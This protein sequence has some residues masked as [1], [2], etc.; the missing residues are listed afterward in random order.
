MSNNNKKLRQRKESQKQARKQMAKKR[1]D[2]P[3]YK[4]ERQGK[5][6]ISTATLLAV[7]CILI[8]TVRCTISTAPLLAA[9]KDKMVKVKATVSEIHGGSMMNRSK[10]V[11]VFKYKVGDKTYTHEALIAT[12][13]SDVPE[14]KKGD[15]TYVYYQ[16][17]D[18]SEAFSGMEI[19]HKFKSITGYIGIGAI[20]LVVLF[21]TEM[22][23]FS[24]L[25]K[26]L[27]NGSGNAG[28]KKNRK[29]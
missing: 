16:K 28:K 14:M 22:N 9:E 7:L 17:D 4:A 3:G 18:P 12:G 15:K 26:N 5:K 25:R 29:H 6:T 27:K 19:D 8:I 1:Q 11:P 13:T 24:M 23:G 10:P 21:L 20:V 2:E